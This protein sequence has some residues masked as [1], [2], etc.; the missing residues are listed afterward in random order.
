MKIDPVGGYLDHF[1]KQTREHHVRLSAQADVKAKMRLT[2]ATLVITLSASYLTVPVLQWAALVM[3]LFCTVSV[4]CAVLAVMPRVPK[5]PKRNVNSPGFN[6]LFFGSFVDLS[7]DEYMGEMEKICND[8][9]R[10]FEAMSKEVYGLGIF[11]AKTKYRYLR[12]SYQFF[13]AGMFSTLVMVIVIEIFAQAGYQV[14]TFM[15]SAP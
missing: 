11:L 3:I 5:G 8:S 4:L 15:V 13:L 6:I 12:W 7:Y 9:G 1:F 10:V 2:V 14:P